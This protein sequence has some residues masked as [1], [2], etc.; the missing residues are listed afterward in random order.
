[1][2]RALPKKTEQVSDTVCALCVNDSPVHTCAHCDARALTRTHAHAQVLFCRLTP[3]QL[4]S[5]RQFL[6]SDA[7][8]AILDGKLNLLYGVDVLRKVSGACVVRVCAVIHC[9]LSA[10]VVVM[11]ML[12]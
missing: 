6:T 11:H 12:S 4:A 3:E 2:L 10:H 5:Y 9:V 1:V 8:S 7:Q